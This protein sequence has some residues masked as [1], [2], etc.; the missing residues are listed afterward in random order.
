[1]MGVGLDEGTI[2]LSHSEVETMRVA[3]NT[4]HYG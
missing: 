1:M 4:A 2:L 3:I